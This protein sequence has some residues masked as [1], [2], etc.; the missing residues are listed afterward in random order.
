VMPTG[1]IL[2]EITPTAMLR[3]QTKALITTRHVG[4]RSRR[5]VD[6][7]L[8]GPPMPPWPPC[9]ATAARDPRTRR[10]KGP[11]RGAGWQGA[12]RGVGR[13][14]DASLLQK[15]Q[16]RTPTLSAATRYQEGQRWLTLP[17]E[18]SEQINTTLRSAYRA[19][20]GVSRVPCV[21]RMAY[22]N[23]YGE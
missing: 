7:E 4:I 11:N 10:K 9:G 5:R 18:S 13:K 19:C 20:S 14:K 21:Q 12:S 15:S 1:D 22:G 2:A 8:W 6:A 16:R 3:R 23:E 17:S